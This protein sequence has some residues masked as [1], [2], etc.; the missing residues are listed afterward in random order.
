MKKIFL[1]ALFASIL[2]IPLLSPKNVLGSVLL[3]DDFNDGNDDGWNVI[4]GNWEVLD[5][6]YGTTVESSFSLAETQAGDYSWSDYEFE[7]DLTVITG[8]DKNIFFRSNEERSV[9]GDGVH[10]W[11]WPT[12]YGI[13][14]TSEKINLRRFLPTTSSRVAFANFS[15]PP[16]HSHRLKVRVVEKNIKVYCDENLLIDFTDNSESPFLTGR[17]AL[18]A[19]TGV[20][21]PT[22]VWYDNVVVTSVKPIPTLTPVPTLNPLILIPGMGGSWNHEKIF[23]GI[24]QDQSSWYKTPFINLYDGLIE[25]LQS[26]GYTLNENLFVFYYDW[27]QP[28]DQSAIDLKDYIDIVINPPPGTNIDLIGHSLGGL[29][30]RA[31]LQNN[32]GSHRIG[33][34]I[35]VGSPHKGAP[36]AYYAWEGA[37]FHRLLGPGERIGAGILLRL[38]G[39]NYPNLVQAVRSFIPSLGN[40]L[41][42][43]SYLKWEATGISKLE[44]AMLQQNIWLKNLGVS[45]ELIS[46]TKALVG[47]SINNTPRWLK[48]AERGRTDKILGRWED[49][50]P[51]N[52]ENA[53]G[54]RSVLE[55]SAR[56]EGAN[57]V[58]LNLSH[59]DLVRASAGQEKILEILGLSSTE[60]VEQP[61]ELFEPALVVIIASPATLR[62]TDPLGRHIGAGVDFSEI[63][64]AIFSDQEKIILIPEAINGNYQV[65]VF[66]ENNGGSYKLLVGQLT[67]KQDVWS[68]Y[69]G[70]VWPEEPD[71]YRISFSNSLLKTDSHLIKLINIKLKDLLRRI[72]YSNLNPFIKIQLI[73]KVLEIFS[74]ARPISLLLKYDLY[75]PAQDYTEKA[76]FRTD[77]TINYAESLAPDFLPMLRE[78]LDL[79]AQT[80]QLLEGV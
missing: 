43:E 18:G 40:L 44:S 77:K 78:I 58:I 6:Q 37:D 26:A 12:G 71:S 50:K 31:Y 23:L 3:Q 10:E 14:V 38:R 55:E 28:I 49:G 32:P 29:V 69:E 20:T 76:I 70:S 2:I 13:H 75:S 79:F 5:G 72:R 73:S 41:F 65:E 53:P 59:G 9:Y 35:T 63:P 60:I 22:K 1:L 8:V 68:K 52:E 25:T 24:D 33:Q 64:N 56:L 47:T 80:Y 42:I 57:I 45:P 46:L 67:E 17:I 7:V 66:S 36:Q 54:D 21:Y 4:R 15:F 30:G 51:I 48:I 62:I 16:G 34:L 27:L 39:F 19:S 11:N 61:K 74:Q